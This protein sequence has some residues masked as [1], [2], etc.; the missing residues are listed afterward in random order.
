MRRAS[1]S[2]RDPAGEAQRPKLLFVV[3]LSPQ[4]VGGMLVL[5]REICR[6]LEERG[7]ST[8]V[9]WEGPMSPAA[10]AYFSG[11][12]HLEFEVLPRQEGFRREHVRNLRR[13]LARHRPEQ[14]VYAF[15][16]ILRLFPWIARL[17]GVRR[18]IYYDHSSRGVGFT[19]RR[20]SLPK[21]L[22]GRFLCRPIWKVI[23][24]SR[25]T[26]RCLEI[27][28]I[29]PADRIAVV[30]NSV[31]THGAAQGDGGAFREK[32]GIPQGR[33]LVVQASWLVP[34]KG[35]D[36][37]LEAAALVLAVE[38]NVHFAVIGSGRCQAEYEALAGKLGIGDHV[39]FTRTVLP[40]TE[41]GVFAAADVCCQFSQWE[42]AF[43]VVIAE[44]MIA[45]RPM[46][47]SR[48]G[49]I[50]E[51]VVEGETGFLVDRR[52]PAEAAQRILELLRDPALRARMGEA[53]RRR[54]LQL[55]DLERNVRQ[56]IEE[57]GI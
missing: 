45:G 39:T 12:E 48:V 52:Q 22:I 15:N 44:A 27:F 30:Y 49:G 50:P 54:A 40:P 34:E 24:V 56:L 25:Y 47:A 43:G 51:I 26:A 42:E 55:F 31:D 10:E 38:P 41:E 2:T 6:R 33:F 7:W 35:I 32:L 8:V 57:W 4:H 9:A 53:G 3:G 11:I 28:G 16:G 23:S 20:W 14:M 5:A 13:I 17:A 36:I 29:Y 18:I 46:V 19:P 37:L 21:R 1:L